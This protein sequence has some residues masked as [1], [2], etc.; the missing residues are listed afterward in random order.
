MS[1]HIYKHL[2]NGRILNRYQL[3]NSSERVNNPWFDE[4][5]GNLD[6][7]R[8]LYTMSGYRLIEH[9]DYLYIIDDDA[10]ELKTDITMKA[11]CLLLIIGK[12][13]MINNYSLDKIMSEKAGLSIDDF[14]QMEQ[15]PY[16]EEILEKA[17][18]TDKKGHNFYSLVLTTLVEREIM[19]EK[20]SAKLFILSDAGKAFFQELLQEQESFFKE[21]EERQGTQ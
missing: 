2:M 9:P 5:M 16:I 3:N 13:L 12:Y 21:T 7:Y 8:H 19:L 14:K 11:Y 10:T 4:I 18:F 1:R 17:K 6:D 20:K 15:V